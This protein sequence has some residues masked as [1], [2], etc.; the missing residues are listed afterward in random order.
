M[1]GYIISSK[2]IEIEIATYYYFLGYHY[3]ITIYTS[4]SFRGGLESSLHVTLTGKYGSVNLDLEKYVYV[5]IPV[6][7]HE[8]ISTGLC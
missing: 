6:G 8:A 4:D 1:V 5:Y 7:H 3:K 2:I